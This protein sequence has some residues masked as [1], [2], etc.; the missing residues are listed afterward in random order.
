MQR[1]DYALF[2]IVIVLSGC[3][4]RQEVSEVPEYWGGYE[5]EKN[6]SLKHD[7]FLIRLSGSGEYALVPEG[8]RKSEIRK[9]FNRPASL[10]EYRQGKEPIMVEGIAYQV[11]VEVVGIVEAGATIKPV[12]VEKLTSSSWFFG[13]GEYL[14]IYASLTSKNYRALE[15]DIEDISVRNFGG[16]K[17]CC[18]NHAPSKEYLQF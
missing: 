3:E 9:H 12:R 17:V 6:Y 14:R 18:L 15:V 5:R 10:E 2:L 11:P 13:S 16:G 1:K 8:S 7:V 4:A